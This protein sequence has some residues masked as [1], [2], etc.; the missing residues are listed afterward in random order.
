MNPLT[1]LD[2]VSIYQTYDET[3][4][5]ELPSPYST[6]KGKLNFLEH[7]L[8]VFA[9]ISTKPNNDNTKISMLNTLKAIPAEGI[10]LEDGKITFDNLRALIMI[11]ARTKR[12]YFIT[13]MT[14]TPRLGSY[15]PLF[16]YAHKL[17]NGVNYDWWDSKDSKIEL[18]MS[19][20][21]Y[22]A[23]EFEKEY[24]MAVSLG[25]DA[26]I[27]KSLAKGHNYIAYPKS[28]R[29]Q[30]V[31]DPTE[32]EVGEVM[33]YPSAWLILDCQFWLAHPDIRDTS[34]ML[35]DI[36]NFGR[37]PKALD[38]EVAGKKTSATSDIWA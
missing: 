5:L 18:A 29:Y 30:E 17:Y 6:S 19:P 8:S 22:K 37:I 3:G 4:K 33:D 2:L 15:T 10:S 23:L 28:L 12:S 14:D 21:L 34:S 16:M 32:E 25:R 1:K 9:K 31:S 26:S 20:H 7:L 35:L 13:K 38:A 27:R 24:P 11:A 36:K